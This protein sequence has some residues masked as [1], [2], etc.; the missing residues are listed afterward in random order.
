MI[1][2]FHET[3]TVKD[4]HNNVHIFVVPT[5]TPTPSKI[6]PPTL[7]HHCVI[8]TTIEGKNQKHTLKEK[9]GQLKVNENNKGR[10][11]KEYRESCL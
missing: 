6:L 8:D 4:S 3:K 10:K 9:W 11:T 5:P 1:Q 7:F 2:R